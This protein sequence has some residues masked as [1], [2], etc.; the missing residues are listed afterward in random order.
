ML[1]RYGLYLVLLASLSFPS[2]I[3]ED[4]VT[5][6]DRI[7]PFSPHLTP[8]PFLPREHEPSSPPV[9]AH[10]RRANSQFDITFVCPNAPQQ[11]CQFAKQGFENAGQYISQMLSIKERV[12][13]HA[14]F[15]SFCNGRR[16]DRCGDMGNTLGMALPASYFPARPKAQSSATSDDTENTRFYLYPQSLVKQSKPDT[17]LDYAPYD[18]MAEFNSDFDFWFKSSGQKIGPN[19]TDFE[20][21]ATHEFTHGMGWDTALVPFSIM[22]KDFS[23]TQNPY[24]A[25]QLYL[26]GPIASPSVDAWTLLTPFDKLVQDPAGKSIEAQVISVQQWWPQG[27]GS[28]SLSSFISSF[29]SSGAPF[30]AAAGLY[31]A[32]TSST[33][34][35]ALRN[36]TLYSTR[37]PGSYEPGSTL[38]HVDTSYSNSQD[39]LMVPTVG[40]MV[41]KTL[42]ELIARFGGRGVYGPGILDSLRLLGWEGNVDLIVGKDVRDGN[43]ASDAPRT[44]GTHWWPA[45]AVGALMTSFIALL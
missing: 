25:P 22:Y 20:F 6:F 39:F 1:S 31:K 35:I 17:K 29:E 9:S 11:T 37:S 24:V 21:V 5:R 7:S 44:A 15:R 14:T 28:P 45:L 38:T 34:S 33:K 43:I 30:S 12:R 19:Q 13:V 41:G 32:I 2:A 3:A 42:D 40:D 4:I 26:H 36:T 10:A 16:K 27:S 18:I 23:S 8:Y